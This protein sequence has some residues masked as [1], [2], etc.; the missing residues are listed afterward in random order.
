MV[1]AW[2]VHG[3]CMVCAW[4]V[5]GVCMCAWS[6]PRSSA[7]PPSL[8]RPRAYPSTSSPLSRS[9]CSKSLASLASCL[10]SDMMAAVML[11]SCV[12]AC[13]PSST[14][15][16]Q[17]RFLTS[18]HRANAVDSPALGLAPERRRNPVFFRT[19]AARALLSG[20]ESSPERVGR[21][22]CCEPENSDPCCSAAR[23]RH[24]GRTAS[25]SAAA[26]PSPP[27]GCTWLQAVTMVA[28]LHG[29]RVACYLR[30]R[31]WPAPAAA[32]PC[33]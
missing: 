3:V 16:S 4:C 13:F 25:P 18:H 15:S 19:Q 1:C 17:S 30:Q 5:H 9:N 20:P 31:L 33:S 11:C 22:G 23:S 32:R 21:V 12:C 10:S 6:R 29:Y 24:A 8:R 26:A 14:R 28:G 2:C 27:P 7:Y